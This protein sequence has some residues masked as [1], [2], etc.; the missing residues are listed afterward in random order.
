MSTG[1]SAAARVDVVVLNFNG[2]ALTKACVDSVI[3][4][5]GADD[6]LLIVDNGSATEDRRAVA[7]HV[8]ALR[9]A[10]VSLLPLPEN[11]GFAGGMEAGFRASSAPMVVLLNNDTVADP[12]WREAMARPFQGPK[13]GAAFAAARSEA[14]GAEAVPVA[15]GVNLF[16]QSWTEWGETPDPAKLR[17]VG[18]ACFAVRRAAVQDVGGLFPEGFFAYYEDV[19]LSWRLRSRGWGIALAPEARVRHVG[20]AT[21][22]RDPNSPLAQRLQALRV[23]NKYLAF[24]RN[25]TTFEFMMLAPFLLGLDAAR[26]I[27]L[28]LRGKGSLARAR[29]RGLGEYLRTPVPGRTGARAR[30]FV[31]VD[32]RLHRL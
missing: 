18:G 11:L 7:D 8:A 6:R 21:L 16:G 2:A 32:F 24:R 9:D 17:I 27:G 28:A 10:R 26:W 25:S 29:A 20:E 14:N 23:R 13:V 12:G 1:S 22:K 15:N 19:D 5:L 30:G 4:Q 3:P 31:T